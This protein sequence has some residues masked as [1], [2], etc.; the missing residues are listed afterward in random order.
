MVHNGKCP[1]C[2]ALVRNVKV[3]DVDIH[4]GLQP[5]WRGFSYLCP[6]C[7]CILGVQMNPLTLN[8]DLST[9]IGKK[10]KRL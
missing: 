7:G 1:C 8:D 6:S 9:S 2:Q 5:R 10:L 3:E 4:V